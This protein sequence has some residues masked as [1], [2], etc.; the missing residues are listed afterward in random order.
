[1][2]GQECSRVH[3]HGRV[4]EGRYLDGSDG[5]F[6]HVIP[7]LADSLWRRSKR[8]RAAVGLLRRSAL[9]DLGH[10][11]AQAVDT[12]F[13]ILY[14]DITKG[15]AHEVACFPVSKELGALTLSLIHIS[16]PTRRTPIS[17]AVF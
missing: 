5:Y 9:G 17:Y 13:D 14:S 12:V 2:A 7:R 3:Q 16:E 11:F 4:E 8:I 6:V 10:R 1:M 15:E